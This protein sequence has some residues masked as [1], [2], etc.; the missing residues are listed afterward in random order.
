MAVKILT[1]ESYMQ[2]SVGLFTESITGINKFRDIRESSAW[3]GLVE[4]LS[5]VLS[6]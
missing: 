3:F 6:Q 4:P 1:N 2:Q 5:F